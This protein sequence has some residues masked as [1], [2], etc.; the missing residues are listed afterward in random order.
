M[1]GKSFIPAAV[2]KTLLAQI[3]P[4]APTTAPEPADLAPFWIQV[5]AALNSLDGTVSVYDLTPT[6]LVAPG[7]IILGAVG[8]S[9][10][11]QSMVRTWRSFT[12]QVEEVFG[13]KTDQLVEKFFAMTQ[14]A[15]ETTAR[16]VLRVEAERKLRTLSEREVYHVFARKLPEHYQRALD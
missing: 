5:E 14:A 6:D 7:P 2:R 8:W 3:S 16:F 4:L 12:A 1:G 15:G 13:L 10:I 9:Q 11:D